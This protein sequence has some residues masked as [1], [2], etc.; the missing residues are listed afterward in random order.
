MKKLLIIIGLCLTTIVTASGLTEINGT[1][2]SV[3]I[4]QALP[5]VIIA[6]PQVDLVCLAGQ[7]NMRGE[8]SCSSFDAALQSKSNNVK[9]YYSSAYSGLECGVNNKGNEGGL[10]LGFS[11]YYSQDNKRDMYL[12]KSSA[13][14]TDLATDWSQGGSNYNIFVADCNNAIAE[15]QTQGYDVSLYV[16]FHQG[17]NDARDATKTANYETNQTNFVATLDVDLDLVPTSY[18]IGLLSTDQTDLDSGNLATINSAKNTVCSG[19]SKVYCIVST[20][21]EVSGDN[22]HFTADGYTCLGSNYYS[23]FSVL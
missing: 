21:C 14:A 10:E 16:F 15:L 1:N 17:E 5:N 4:N 19:N 7:S 18:L 12:A 20:G 8:A 11:Y 3:T 13:S 23:T 2:T 22:L 6:K 9:I